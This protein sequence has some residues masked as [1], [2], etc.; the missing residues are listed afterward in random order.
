MDKVTRRKERLRQYYLAH[1]EKLL[2]ASKFITRIIPKRQ[3]NIEN[4]AASTIQKEYR[5]RYYNKNKEKIAEKIKAWRIANPDRVKEYNR[6]QKIK[7][8]E[9]ACAI[10]KDVI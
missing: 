9:D 6:R 3:K 7:R 1:R 10:S 8:S 2:A 4:T 5:L